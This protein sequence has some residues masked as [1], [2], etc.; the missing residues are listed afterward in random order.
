MC[1]PYGDIIAQCLS[2]GI[3]TTYEY[4]D[5]EAVSNEIKRNRDT[6]LKIA[7]KPPKII[8]EFCYLLQ[9]VAVSKELGTRLLKGTV[10][11]I[12]LCTCTLVSRSQT[13]FSRFYLWGREK[14]SGDM[15]STSLRQHPKKI[16]GRE[17]L[18]G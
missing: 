14:G 15:V 12:V 17:I 7:V 18:G 8:E 16:V 2:T 9:S 5:L 10:L 4:H 3:V 6:V 13:A 11:C 1:L